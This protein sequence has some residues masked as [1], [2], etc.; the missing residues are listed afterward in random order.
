MNALVSAARVEENARHLVWPTTEMFLAEVKRRIELEHR[1]SSAPKVVKVGDKTP[2]QGVLIAG[3]KQ[4]YASSIVDFARDCIW[5]HEPRNAALGLPTKLPLCPFPK[6]EEFLLWLVDRAR[7]RT[8]APV[9]KSRDSG[10]TWMAAVFAVHSWLF[11][12]GSTFGFGSRKEE[13][14]DIRGEPSSIFEKIRFIIRHLP[15]YLKP[16]GLNEKAHFNHRRIVNPENASAIVGEAG[17]N[18]GRGA[19]TS[20]YVIDEAAHIERPAAL[21]AALTA[22]TDCRIDISSPLVGTLFNQW[23]ATEPRKFIFDIDDAP[24]HTP[25]WKAMKEA[26]LTAKGL[27][28]LYAQEYLRDATAG[29]EGQLIKG[30]WVEAIVGAAEKLGLAVTG[31]RRVG[32]DPADGGK[33]PA[34]AAFMHGFEVLDVRTL[35]NASSG[36]AGHWA[37]GEAKL[38][39]AQKVRYETTGVGAGAAEAMRNKDHKADGL[40]VEGWNPAGAVWQPE[41]F[42][43]PAGVEEA[44]DTSGKRPDYGKNRIKNKDMFKNAKAQAWWYLRDRIYATYCAIQGKTLG[45]FN[46][47]LI[48]SLSAAISELSQVKS[49]LCQVVYKH[50]NAG[51]IVIDKTPDGF[52]SPNRADAIMIATAPSQIKSMSIIGFF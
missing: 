12:D 41:V 34:A 19:R 44:R 26:E 3:A 28:H 16:R 36:Q 11:L 32:L 21:E 18:I 42:Y 17:D 50:D 22:T 15:W 27:G 33:D 35:A 1:I 31:E 20:V 2:T 9:E 4:F 49:E 5:V 51:R 38:F 47:D 13:L 30:V 29:I 46:V 43:V 14:V 37:Y 8:S 40:T 39:G 10:A 23:C 52:M 25:E 6:Q 7:T 24:W 48:L 45:G